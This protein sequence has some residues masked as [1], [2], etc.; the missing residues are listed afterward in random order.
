MA[1]AGML[2]VASCMIQKR[3]QQLLHAF[4]CPFLKQT[5]WKSPTECRPFKSTLLS[6]SAHPFMMKSWRSIHHSLI[7]DRNLVLMG[8]PG[9]GK[10]TIGRL[11]GQRLGLPVIDVDDDVLEK[12]WNM[13][14]SEKLQDVGNEQFLEEEGK[15]LLKWSASGSVISLSG[16]NPMHSASMEHLKKNSIVVYLDVHAGEIVDRLE[17]MKIDRIVGQSSES[18]MGDILQYRKHFYKKW[19]DFRVLCE[20]GD[21]TEALAEKVLHGIKRYENSASETFT[22]TR[23]NCLK[24][25]KTANSARTFSEV[26]VDG[27]ASDGGLFVPDGGVPKLTKGEWMRLKGADYIERAQVILERCIPPADIPAVKLGEMIDLA[28]GKNFAC[29]QIAPVRHLMGN[30]FLLELF[31]GPTASFKDL[32]LQI[33][34]QMF[35]YCVPRTCNS[36]ILTATSGDTGSAVLDGFSRLNDIDKQR[37]AVISLFPENGVSPI[38]KSQLLGCQSDNGFSVGVKSDFDFCQKTLKHMLTNSNYTGFLAAE[39]GTALSTA[40]SINWA[41][42]VPQVVYHASAYLDLVS[43]GVIHFGNPIDVCIPTGNFGNILSA[44][45]AKLMGIPIRKFICASNQNNV[46]T[47]FIKT[48]HYDLRNRKLILTTSPAIDILKSSNLER[49]VHLISNGNGQLVNQL[50]SQLE[51]QGHFQLP[52]DLLA[53][54][55]KDMVADWCSEEDCLAAIHSVYSNSGYVLDTHTAVAKAVADRLQDKT[56]PLVIASTAHYSKFAS[57]IL[58]ALRISQIKQNPLSQLHLLHSLNPLPPAHAALLKTLK[59]SENNDH[60]VCAADQN[61]MMDHVETTIHNLFF[62]VR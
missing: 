58:K 14:V 25:P 40:N 60:Q 2:E 48:G 39:Y 10:T 61:V 51:S 18:S 7:G 47:E 49:Y 24:E 53:R 57:T 59:K 35:A 5:A 26:I 28:Y 19:H 34:P 22:S 31:H 16:S 32:A 12:D 29:N 56:C 52:N 37:I 15:A 6:P 62:R 38:Q 13:S 9:A 1:S 23:S 54:L 46:L 21:T 33:M 11:L 55:Q 30:Q 36:L 20:S 43:Q 50:F 4:P 17:V 27:L 45:Y 3:K 42:L 8:P 44:I 41:R